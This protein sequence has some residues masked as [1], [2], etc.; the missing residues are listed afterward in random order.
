V[1]EDVNQ[2]EHQ[3]DVDAPPTLAWVDAS[4]VERVVENLVLNAVRHTAPG[5]PVVIRVHKNEEGAVVCVE[6][7]GPG[8]PDAMKDKVFDAF[9]RVKDAPRQAAGT[10]IGLSLVAGFAEMHGGRAWVEDREGGGS[11]FKVVFPDVASPEPPAEA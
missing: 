10:G 11:A 2:D 6:D 5:T 8:I 3:I 4:K 7:Q 1:I 9:V